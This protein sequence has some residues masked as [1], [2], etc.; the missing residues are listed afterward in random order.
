MKYSLSRNG[1]V[2]GSYTLDELR[3]YM[4]EGR[5]ALSDQ[6][7]PEGG[8]EW[9]SVA[10]VLEPTASS[11]TTSG[12]LPPLAPP[13]PPVPPPKPNNHLVTSILVTLFCCLPLGIAA[14]VF[15]AQVDSK[16][17]RGDYAG[18]VNSAKNAVIF[19]WISFGLGLVGVGVYF[20]V[21]VLGAA[22]NLNQ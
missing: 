3:K 22:A 21:M 13:A 19:S 11:P 20:M 7:L 9:V 4:T 5:V 6:L 15:S 17:A 8:T 1:Q 10:Q 16:H 12:A 2:I 14:I 18:A